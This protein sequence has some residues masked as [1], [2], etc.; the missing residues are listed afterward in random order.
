MQGGRRRVRLREDA[1]GQAS[2][3]SEGWALHALGVRLDERNQLF[4]GF[5][6]DVD[7]RHARFDAQ[8]SLVELLVPA[9]HPGLRPGLRRPGGRSIVGW[10]QR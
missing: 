9:L 6:A 2:P 1:A 10:R 8:L 5:L 4:P 7:F 3:P